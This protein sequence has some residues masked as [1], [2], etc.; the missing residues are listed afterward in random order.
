MT[1]EI[2]D[3]VR[4]TAIASGEQGIAWLA[5][6]PPL[7]AHVEREWNL[8]IGR[9]YE[10]GTE[11]FVA[12]AMTTDGRLAVV[13]IAMLWLDPQR[14]ELATLGAAKGR[15]YE[16][17]LRSDAHAGIVLLERLGRQLHELQLPLDNRWRSSARPC[18][19]RGGPCRLNQ[20]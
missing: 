19:M 1:R 20:I 5:A 9:T 3:K 18:A 10:R 17:V 7:V 4:K 11:A 6:L 14:R 15:G 12:E 13:K 2:P 8:S 16:R